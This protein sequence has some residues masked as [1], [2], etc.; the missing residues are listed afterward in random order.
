MFLWVEN[1]VSGLYLRHLQKL[2]FKINSAIL[3]ATSS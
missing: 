1:I 2:L 3:R